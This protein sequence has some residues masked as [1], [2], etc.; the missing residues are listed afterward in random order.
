MMPADAE[1]L[2]VQAGTELPYF[3]I[4]FFEITQTNEGIF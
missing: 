2:Y 1:K 3:G 4:E